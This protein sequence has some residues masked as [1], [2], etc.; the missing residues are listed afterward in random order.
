MTGAQQ[1]LKIPHKKLTASTKLGVFI[2]TAAATLLIVSCSNPP[3]KEEASA[4]DTP[5]THTN[6]A[7][8]PTLKLP[9]DPAQ[10]AIINKKVAAIVSQM[11]LEQKVG[12]MTQAE[13]GFVTPEDVKKYH[14]GSV[15]E[16]GG[17][18]LDGNK[19][20]TIDDWLAKLDAFYEAAMDT[21]DGGLP[22]PLI[23]GTD[24]VHGHNKVIGATIFP[25]NIGLGATN[26]PELVRKIGEVTAIETMVLG[27]DW[28][29]APEISVTRNDRWGRT[30]EGYS[31]DAALVAS[32]GQAAIEGL[33]GSIA[34]GTFMDGRRLLA[35]A[36]H[37][38]GDGGTV[39]GVDRADNIAT[40]QELI[41]IHSPGY[42]SAIESGVLSIM[43]S[44]SSWQGT[45]MH[46]HRYLI[47]DILKNKLGFDGFVV[48]DWNSHALVDGCEPDNCPEAIAA[49]LDMFMVPEH[50][51]S[52]ITNTVQQV[53]DGVVPESHIDDAVSRI[54][55]S[56]FRAGI[57]TAP[58]PSARQLAGN[59]ALFG[60]P[61]H[62]QLARQ[63]VRES[64]VLLKN[65]NA[66]L[67]L[68]PNSRVLVTGSAAD[69]IGRQSGGWTISWQGTGTTN[70]D[71]PQGKSI[72]QGIKTHVEAAG[73]HAE[74][75]ANGEYTQ[76]PDVAIMVF[77]EKPYAEWQGDIKTLA[78]QPGDHSDAKLMETLKA[79]GIKVISVFISGRPLWLNRE[80][81][82]SDAFIAAWLPGSQGAGVADL[83]FTDQQGK[84]T[85][86]FTGTLPLSWPKAP[87]QYE[88]NV[89]DDDYDPLFPFGYGLNYTS[90][91]KHIPTLNTDPG[92][93]LDDLIMNTPLFKGRAREPW[94]LF[95]GSKGKKTLYENNLISHNAIIS[96]SE[97]D[98]E[99][100]GDAIDVKWSGK[101]NGEISLRVSDVPLNFNEYIDNNSIIA[102]DVYRLTKAQKPIYLQ[103]SDTN[104]SH[105]IDITLKF[106]AAPV[107]EWNRLS[108]DIACFKEA[109][110]DINYIV[111][112]L[113]FVTNGKVN[114]RFANIQIEPNM[115]DK[116]AFRCR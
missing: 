116:A 74:Y 90:T 79:Q 52:F 82:A 89:G 41:D 69:D 47:K 40:E 35:T 110:L 13:V 14:L 75:Q 49:G 114:A 44:H 115:A 68:K 34:D 98:Q 61:E 85:Y 113:G 87:D 38:V 4:V 39:D 80:I 67:P 8:W 104:K 63:A 64:A 91:Q 78:W 46:G 15:L 62:I 109:G 93:A 72:W 96:V 100:Q 16:G 42:F 57:M 30:Y 71:F 58:K 65:N 92:N 22:I 99:T 19:F 84:M 81:N 25:H 94:Q 12:Q 11:T 31:E 76:K 107:N 77:G 55:R 48:G 60:A 18:Y 36:K 51:K 6:P 105:K 24:S 17:S 43:A 10:T 66:A 95:V 103:A 20:A 7:L 9:F 3:L 21:S 112:A 23:W 27:K 83:L 5:V 33:Q 97:A 37:Y 53:R 26:N 106:N 59:T 86:D 1:S 102:F 73:G 45:R 32:L 50:W 29:F 101:G 108:V 88:V 54:L 28:T 70:E 111:E 2:A 56:K